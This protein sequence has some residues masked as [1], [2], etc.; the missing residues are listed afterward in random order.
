M[1][2]G[3]RS[4]TRISQRYLG[5]AKFGG[6]PFAPET[7]RR[8]ASK[9]PPGSGRDVRG[10]YARGAR[11]GYGDDGIG[12]DGGLSIEIPEGRLACMFTEGGGMMGS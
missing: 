5:A 2:G 6:P 10:L 7:E 11:R 3:T 12:V 4:S 8:T 9:W 1:I